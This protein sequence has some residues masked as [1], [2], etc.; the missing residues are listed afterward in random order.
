MT[1]LAGVASALVARTASHGVATRRGHARSPARAAP[2]LRLEVGAFAAGDRRPRTIA[3]GARTSPP[4]DADDAVDLGRL[5]VRAADEHAV[6]V[7]AVDEHL[8][9]LADERVARRRGDRVLH[10]AALAQPLVHRARRRP[11]RRAS[12][13]AVPSSGENGK[14]PA[15]SSRASREEREQLVVVGLGLAREPDDER[16]AE[17]GVGLVGADAVDRSSRKRSP[18]PHRFMRAQQRAATRAAARGRS[19]GTT[20]GSSSIV[21]TSGSC[22]SRRIEVEQADAREAVRREPAS[23]RRSSGASEPGSPTSRPYHARSC[24]TS[25]ISA[26]PRSTRP[27]ASASID[28]G[29]RDR[30]LPRNDGI[31]Q[32]AH[33]RSQPSATFTYAHGARRRG[34]RQLEQVAHAGRACGRGSD[35]RSASDALAREADDR[36]GL[37]QRGRELVAVALGHAAGDHELR[38]GPLRVGERERD[39]DRLLAGRLDERAGVDDD[40][41]GVLGRRRPASSP[42]ASSEATTLSESTA[43]FGQPSVS[44]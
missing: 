3:P 12:R 18:L 26:T 4:V 15:Q 21:A 6:V 25:T 20:V 13:P 37:G 40:E 27:R 31:A 42:S 1:K 38:A 39:V 11:R 7:D 14:N 9:R 30:C 10:L 32:N 2:A 16:R 41:V 34:P 8:D 36:V 5:A 43:F 19:T 35:R 44:T 33:A 29:V 22:T 24:A 23:S 28:S 17:R